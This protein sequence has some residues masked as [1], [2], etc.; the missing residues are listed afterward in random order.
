MCLVSAPAWPG[1]PAP[2]AQPEG[3]GLTGPGRRVRRVQ[4]GALIL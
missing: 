2:Q 4:R 3:P 1:A